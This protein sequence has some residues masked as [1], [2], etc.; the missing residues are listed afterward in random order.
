MHP[1]TLSSGRCT[2][3]HVLISGV[4]AGG[5]SHWATPPVQNE[6]ITDWPLHMPF[7]LYIENSTYRCSEVHQTPLV[8]VL[9]I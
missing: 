2:W 1:A 7:A 3:V 8:F 9:H 6:Q 5:C 4:G